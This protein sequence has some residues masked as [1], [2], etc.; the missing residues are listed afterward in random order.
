MYKVKEHNRTYEARFSYVTHQGC[1]LQGCGIMMDLPQQQTVYQYVLPK[2]MA[3]G[4]QETQ[5]VLNVVDIFTWVKECLIIVKNKPLFAVLFNNLVVF[6]VV[7]DL[8]PK[9]SDKLCSICIV[10][11]PAE[12]VEPVITSCGHLMCWF[13]IIG[14]NISSVFAFQALPFHCSEKL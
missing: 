11:D 10:Q 14:Q 8:S 1:P 6:V 13:V 3:A 5:Q 7:A 12:V 4:D 2:D 9:M